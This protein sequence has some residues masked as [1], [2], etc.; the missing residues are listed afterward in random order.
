V[1]FFAEP[2]HQIGRG[3]AIVFDKENFAA[4]RSR[5]PFAAAQLQPR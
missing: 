2:A 3:L 5:C 4:H 1:P